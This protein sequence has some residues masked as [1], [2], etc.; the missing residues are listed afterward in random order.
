MPVLTRGHTGT[1]IAGRATTMRPV[2]TVLL[3]RSPACYKELAIAPWRTDMNLAARS[4]T[5][6]SGIGAEPAFPVGDGDDPVLCIDRPGCGAKSQLPSLR[7]LRG[8]FTCDRVA[9]SAVN[10][11]ALADH[12]IRVRGVFHADGVLAGPRRAVFRTRWPAAFPVARGPVAGALPRVGT[13]L[14]ALPFMP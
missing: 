5:A 4:R 11:F 14:P 1:G 7:L 13:G 9:G 3:S 10:G 12:D 6:C 8:R 2:A